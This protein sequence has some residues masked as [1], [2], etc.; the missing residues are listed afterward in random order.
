MWHGPSIG[1]VSGRIDNLGW[2]LE[3][4]FYG[5]DTLNS[6]IRMGWSDGVTVGTPANTI[7]FSV[8]NGVAAGTWYGVTRAASTEAV[9]QS[10]AQTHDAAYHV[11]KMICDGAGEV[12]WY[13]DDTLIATDNS[14][15]PTEGMR[16]YFQMW[17][18]DGAAKS[19]YLDWVKL[20]MVVD[21]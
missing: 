15:V 18:T 6:V 14:N 20:T 11:M 1:D 9:S 4:G 19:S 7:S 21:R 17:N 3:W 16:I 2:T 13:V 12:T 10:S 5:N 8:T